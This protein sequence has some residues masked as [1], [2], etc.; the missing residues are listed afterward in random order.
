VSALTS[1]LY[2]IRVKKDEQYYKALFLK[3]W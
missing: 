1:G 3:E 2:F